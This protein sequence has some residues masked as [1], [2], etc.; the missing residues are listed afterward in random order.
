MWPIMRG[1][2]FA[3]QQNWTAYRALTKE[4]DRQHARSLTV[5]QRFAIY[6]DLLALVIN[7]RN[8]AAGS[9]RAEQR[10]WTEKL[11]MRRRL[12]EIFKTA[13]QHRRG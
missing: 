9:D 5:E 8:A 4:V 6:E 13:D 7:H 10:R 2:S 11:A 3:P 12:N 1:M